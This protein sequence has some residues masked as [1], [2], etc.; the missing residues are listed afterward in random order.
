MK[1]YIFITRI[2]IVRGSVDDPISDREA[3]DKAWRIRQSARGHSDREKFVICGTVSIDGI[4]SHVL[5]DVWT[6]VAQY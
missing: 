4:D 3:T 6:P 1:D 2:A 5:V